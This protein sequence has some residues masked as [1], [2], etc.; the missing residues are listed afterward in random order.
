V[1]ELL[2]AEVEEE[3][4]DAKTFESFEP[5]KETIAR[6]L[7]ETRP[8]EVPE[9]QRD[10]SWKAEHVAA[11]WKDIEGFATTYSTEKALAGREYFLGSAVTVESGTSIL[12]L[13]GQQRLATATI[14]LAAFRDA[15]ESHHKNSS[16]WAQETFIITENPVKGTTFPH[17]KL[18]LQDRSFF[19]EAIQKFPREEVEP[20]MK[21]HQRI[22]DAY[23]FLRANFGAL[24]ENIKPEKDATA[25]AGH[26]ITV[27]LE[28]V[29]VINVSTSNADHAADVFE[30]LN[31]RGIGLSGT[32]LL[33]SHLLVHAEE[34][35]RQ[36][37]NEHWERAFQTCGVNEEAER[38]IRVSWTSEHGDVKSTKLPKLIREQ[39]KEGKL[40]ILEYSKRLDEDASRYMQLVE[41]D[42]DD[43]DLKKYYMEA[44][45]FKLNAAYPMLVAVLRA[46]PTE[47]ETALRAAVSLIVRQNVVAGQVT[48]KLESAFFAAAKQTHQD[49][50]FA[51]ALGILRAASP[52]AKVF[53]SSFLRL[54]FNS[55]GHSTAK[56]LLSGIERQFV[57][58]GEKFIASARKVHVEHIYPQTPKIG[59]KWSDHNHWV[60]RIGNLTLLSS[61]LNT[62]LKNEL[63]AAKASEYLK[64]DFK[65]TSSLSTAKAWS[66]KDVEKRQEVLCDLAAKEWPEILA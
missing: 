52:D 18:N 48:G 51:N 29:R 8:I 59:D 2:Q 56:A 43:E 65:L 14:M 36:A 20:T 15:V 41:G 6:M 44:K 30:T 63:I 13:D 37:V 34:G 49:K 38:L 12:L 11:F 23:D 32:D 26:I 31:D 7:S 39:V 28:H 5:K 4:A 24:W 50:K 53:R 60:N 64:S 10:Y 22:L 1:S 55:Y 54:E 61:K 35:K 17:L 66:Q 19:F 46:C 16:T 27:L 57:G 21:S 45:Y 33:R 9:Y 25:R 40:D 3:M 62:A 47:F 42:F 58:T